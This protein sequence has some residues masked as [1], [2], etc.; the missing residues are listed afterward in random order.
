VILKLYSPL[1]TFFSK[2]WR[3]SE[4]EAVAG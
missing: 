2:D 1:P 4:I 3:L